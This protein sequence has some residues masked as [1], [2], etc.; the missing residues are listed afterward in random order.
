MP[1]KRPD[2]KWPHPNVRWWGIA[3]TLK[4]AQTGSYRMAEWKEKIDGTK[5]G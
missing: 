5:R 3:S 2:D 1:K 4:H